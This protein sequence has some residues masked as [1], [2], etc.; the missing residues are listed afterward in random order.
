MTPS[1]AKTDSKLIIIIII[2]IIINITKSII[3]KSRLLFFHHTS[4]TTKYNIMLRMQM[5]YW[6]AI[7]D[8]DLAGRKIKEISRDLRI[9]CFFS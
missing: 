4:F 2:I 6:V 7:V 1:D 8:E 9:L 3:K 5:L